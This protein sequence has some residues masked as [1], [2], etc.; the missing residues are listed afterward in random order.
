M[1]TYIFEVRNVIKITVDG[2]TAS[3]AREDL[4][5]HLA[6]YAFDMIEDCSVSDGEVV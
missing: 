5:N 3:A 4:I 1:S 6:C 2:A